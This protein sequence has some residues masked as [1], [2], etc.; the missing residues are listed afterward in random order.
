M[1]AVRVFLLFGVDPLNAVPLDDFR[2]TTALHRVRWPQIVA[3]VGEKR[4]SLRRLS[5]RSTRSAK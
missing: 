1:A 4:G 2:T 3:E 5:S